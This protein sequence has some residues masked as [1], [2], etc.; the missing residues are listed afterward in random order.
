MRALRGL[1]ASFSIGQLSTLAAGQATK[2]FSTA[3]ADII[4]VFG[5]ETKPTCDFSIW[6]NARF[7]GAA[8]SLSKTPKEGPVTSMD[9]S[10]PAPHRSRLLWQVNIQQRLSLVV[11]QSS[12]QCQIRNLA[13]R[14]EHLQ[15]PHHLRRNTAD[16][17]LKAASG[18][19]SLPGKAS[20][21]PLRGVL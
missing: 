1:A 7:P 5:L 21:F 14:P 3:V 17:G 19:P 8:P 16:G 2:V 13:V 12:A 15:P 10:A 6:K 20:G 9:A 4:E 18:S 11:S